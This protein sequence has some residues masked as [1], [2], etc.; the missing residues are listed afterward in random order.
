MQNKT[1]E[2]KKILSEF[3]TNWFK[4]LLENSIEIFRNLEIALFYLSIYIH[5]IYFKTFLK[6]NQI[7]FLKLIRYFYKF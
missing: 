6:Q 3:V 2:K 7:L 1:T 4:K 5:H